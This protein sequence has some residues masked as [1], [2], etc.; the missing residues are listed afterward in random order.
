MFYGTGNNPIV[1]LSPWV[2]IYG[3]PQP[4]RGTILDT[5]V[6]D[7]GHVHLAAT[8]NCD[9]VWDSGGLWSFGRAAES[10][11]GSNLRGVDAKTPSWVNNAW[12]RWVT[13]DVDKARNYHWD[14]SSNGTINDEVGG[15][16]D[17]GTCETPLYT[18]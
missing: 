13:L 8:C 9:Q 2:A 1:V 18:P 17:P 14:T 15:G 16:A 4:F 11:L 3:F 10:N 12:S 7:G 6:D 5:S